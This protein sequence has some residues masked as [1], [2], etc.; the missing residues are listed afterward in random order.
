MKY[1]ASNNN[2]ASDPG[3]FHRDLHN[4]SNNKLVNVYI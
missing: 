3:T 2:N 1:R 4:Y